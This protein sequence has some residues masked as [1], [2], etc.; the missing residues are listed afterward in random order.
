[1]FQRLFAGNGEKAQSCV[2]LWLNIHIY[3]VFFPNMSVTIVTNLKKKTDLIWPSVCL[4]DFCPK[5]V[6]GIRISCTITTKYY[7]E[8]KK[9]MKSPQSDKKLKLMAQSI[10][11]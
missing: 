8:E 2:L 5:M 1:M 4:I 7:Q 10:N 3:T 11:I 9:L 6:E